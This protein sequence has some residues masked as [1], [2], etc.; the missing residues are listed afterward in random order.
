MSE[1]SFGRLILEEF[2]QFKK[3]NMFI[4]NLILTVLI[5]FIIGSI[6]AAG[7]VND[8]NTVVLDMDHTSASQTIIRHFNDHERFKIIGEVN[9]YAELQQ[10]LAADKAEIALVFP[11]NMYQEIKKGKGSDMLMIID[12]SNYIIANSAYAKA[13]EILQ[14][15]NG[16]ISIK[17]M[18][19]KGL[20]PYE[21]TT[22]ASSLL[23]EHKY[24]YNQN[25]YSFY[26]SYGILAAGIFSLL[27]SSIGITLT[28]N[29]KREAKY[30]LKELLAKVVFFSL[31]TTLAINNAF[32]LIAYF[33]HLPLA[34]TYLGFFLIS[35]FYA[36]L[37]SIFGVMLFVLVGHESRILQAS[38]FF[39]TVLFFATGFT[40]PYKAIPIYL[41][42]I[43]FLCP[44]TPFLNGL[45]ANL[46]MGLGLNYTGKYLIWLIAQTAIYLPLAFILYIK[47]HEIK[48]QL[49][50]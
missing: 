32:L 48:T 5:V 21:A 34:G 12:Q 40:W 19:A 45:R 7:V 30:T 1:R 36:L 23:V 15:I 31:I 24:L 17:L 11:P 20:T 13:Y 29:Y 49:D 50:I 18:N 33:Y 10:V 26:L 2:P 35:V 14:T 9:S 39:A 47:K 42:P 38:S 44:F 27:M 28:Q 46:V 41:K 22:T 3:Y 16:G 6:Y 25:N 8:V 4:V 43:Y 37:I